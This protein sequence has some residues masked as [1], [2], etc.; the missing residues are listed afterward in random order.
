M[1]DEVK[2]AEKVRENTP[3]PN[4]VLMRFEAI[5]ES[6]GAGTLGVVRGF[7]KGTEEEVSLLVISNPQ[8]K[9]NQPPMVPVAVMISGDP[10]EMFDPPEAVPEPSRII[11]PH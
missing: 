5:L 3:H 9:L 1:S 11:K 4:D 7:K 6:G 10:F 2:D 8:A